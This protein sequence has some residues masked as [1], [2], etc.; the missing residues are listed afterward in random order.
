MSVAI[1]L[2]LVVSTGMASQPERRLH[3]I[4][5]VVDTLETPVAWRG[6]LSR[7]AGIV[8]FAAGRGRFG[9]TAVRAGPAVA[10]NGVIVAAPLARPGDYYLFDSTGFVL[11]RSST[12]TF[13]RFELTRS[14][15][16]HTGRFLPGQFLMKNTPWHTDTLSNDAARRLRQ[17]ALAS[18]HWHLDSLDAR[19]PVRLY[20]RG[21]LELRDAPASEVGVARW[22]GVAAAIASRPGGVSGLPRDRLQVTSVALLRRP[23]DRDNYLRYLGLLTPLELAAIDIDRSRL[24]LPMGYTETRWPGFE[25]DSSVRAPSRDGSQH[26]R[27][28]P[29]VPETRPLRSR[30]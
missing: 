4:R 1:V 15:Y 8:E 25:R 10:L 7:A 5:F 21:W 11:V 19:G 17:H 22:F 6:Q 30:R 3:G 26:W 29:G 9:V 13:S 14:D 28:L 12:R 18:I 20:A 24:V 27:S 23:G 2:S 16:N